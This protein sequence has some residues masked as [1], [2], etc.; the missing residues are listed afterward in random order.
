MSFVLL[1]VTCLAGGVGA[2]GRWWCDTTVQR[3]TQSRHPIGTLA[4]NVLG[5]FLLGVLV[6]IAG[7]DSGSGSVQVL[8]LGLL[9]G[10]TTFS[11]SVVQTVRAAGTDGLGTGV[12]HATV[13]ALACVIAALLGLQ[14]G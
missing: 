4:V 8:G 12:A 2:A 7:A 13:T 11:S 9:G 5:S 14:L 6:A 1:V 10:F 3:M